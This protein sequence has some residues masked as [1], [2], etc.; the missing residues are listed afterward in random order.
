M[1]PAV[2]KGM[3][4]L[5]RLVVLVCAMMLLLP[6]WAQSQGHTGTQA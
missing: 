5:K 2:F 6:A 4:M 1:M 3:P